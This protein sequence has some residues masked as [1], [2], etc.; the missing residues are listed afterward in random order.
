VYQVNG[1]DKVLAWMMTAPIDACQAMLDWLPQLAE[2][3]H[4]VATAVRQRRGVP[5]YTAAV[6]GTTAF[7]DY[8]VVDQYET[9]MIIDVVDQPLPTDGS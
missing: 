9:V 2:S 1:E 5:A 3:P 4:A 6:P 7:V 8:T